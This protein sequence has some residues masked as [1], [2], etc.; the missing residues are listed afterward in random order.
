MILKVKINEIKSIDYLEIDLPIDK[1]LYA[2]TGQNGSG[3]STIVTSA[4]TVFYN[5]SMED[6]FGATNDESYISFY[7]DGS[8]R[9][10]TNENG[11]WNS[12]RIGD[13][14]LK[15]FY[16][17]SVVFGNRFRNMSFRVL[18]SIVKVR[19]EKLIKS[20]DYIRTNLGQIL[21]NDPGYYEELH[22]ITSDKL[23]R[24]YNFKGEIFFY[25]KNGRRVSQFHMSTGENLLISVL[26]SLYIRNKQRGALSK[27]CIIF[28]DEI[29]LALHPASLK[30]LLAFLKLASDEYN[31]AIYFST[32]SIEL[33]S[34]IKPDHI[35][36]VERHV[37]NTLEVLNPCYPAYATRTLYDHDGYDTLILVEDD[38]A[39]DII[40]ILLRHN[41]L[42]SNKL[43]HV[44]PTGGYTNT[45]EL[46]QEVV[47]SNLIGK[48]SK[49]VIILD[50][51][52]RTE[53]QAYINKYNIK[54]N[55]P[56]NYL[57]IE[58]LEKFLKSKLVDS[59]DHKF[60]RHL[61]D[62]IFHAKSLTE[63]I[64][65]YKVA[66]EPINDKSG[67]S[68]FKHIIKEV[69]ERGKSREELV[70]IVSSYLIEEN[71]Q[72]LQKLTKFLKEKI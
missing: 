36:F 12:S 16:E 2:I 21:H 30:R 6:F 72:S 50:G 38:L 67:K 56:I 71:G 34:Q 42:L 43:V 22:E 44:L 40:K 29:E 58:S 20:N 1:G 47:S 27:S 5:I 13:M 23:D 15:G 37:D 52:I 11:K 25:R 32:H 17:G 69:Q 24:T 48:V 39:K 59:V 65:E 33:I 41:R 57:P 62:Y 19:D 63:V 8:E 51:D 28:L 18:K 64:K 53:A 10:W 60:F 49:V 31:Y 14:N 9:H 35:F 61:N 4:A 46:G 26:N 54:N 45:I 55:I 7:L 3:K 70:N 66:Y 68:L